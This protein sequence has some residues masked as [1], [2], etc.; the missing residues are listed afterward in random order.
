M[1]MK[2]SIYTTTIRLP[3]AQAQRVIIAAQAADISMAQWLRRSVAEK[4]ERD[5]HDRAALA[6]HAAHAQMNGDTK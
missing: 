6:A 2:I 5:E 1:A 3:Y 4:L